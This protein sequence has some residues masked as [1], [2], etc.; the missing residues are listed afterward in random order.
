MMYVILLLFNPQTNCL[1]SPKHLTE[2]SNSPKFGPSATTKETDLAI[3]KIR[4][5]QYTKSTI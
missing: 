2:S 5:L 1:R 3:S 4:Y